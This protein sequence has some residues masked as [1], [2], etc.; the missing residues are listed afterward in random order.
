MKCNVWVSLNKLYS[1]AIVGCI[2]GLIIGI[3][4]M[5]DLLHSKNHYLQNFLEGFN[6]I[7]K[8][9]V[10]FVYISTGVSF[11]TFTGFKWNL[12]I[13]KKHLIVTFIVRYIIL[14]FIGILWI[15]AWKTF[16][17]G[18]VEESKV[19]RI[20]LFIPFCIPSSSNLII[21][22]NLLKYFLGETNILLIWQN[23]LMV[24]QLLALY[25]VYFVQ[26]GY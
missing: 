5:R 4:G 3:S 22:L 12:P 10:A 15:L 2:L 20:S 7:T 18:I 23:G 16:Y 26:I 11:A 6:I 17:G 14:P 24:F 25:V 9:T 1:P 21:I 8:S 13:N 19:F